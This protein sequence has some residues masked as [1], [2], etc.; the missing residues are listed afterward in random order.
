MAD[1]ADEY[2]DDLYEEV[3]EVLVFKPKM[4]QPLGVR[5]KVRR[6]RGSNK[7]GLRFL[8]GSMRAPL[9]S[10]DRLPV[11]RDRTHSPTSATS[12]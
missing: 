11:T 1:A 2:D 9:P 12:F 10:S 4:D 8:G 7:Q 5:F 6:V 3:Q